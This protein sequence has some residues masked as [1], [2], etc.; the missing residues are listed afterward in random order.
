MGGVDTALARTEGRKLKRLK[1]EHYLRSKEDDRK[2]ANITVQKDDE[3]T[4]EEEL[5]TMAAKV[6]SYL[7]PR[8]SHRATKRGS[9]PVVT[10]ELSA[11]LHR[12]NV[13]S[14]TATLILAETA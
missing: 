9:V 10:A 1:C 5:A 11:A 13:S 12:A 3:L 4:S 7:E 2:R 6:E 14:R 8:C